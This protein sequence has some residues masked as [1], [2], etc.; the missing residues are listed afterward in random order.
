MTRH[1]GWQKGRADRAA[2]SLSPEREHV[3]ATLAPGLDETEPR[4][5][6]GST[7]S[8]RPFRGGASISP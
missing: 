7:R 8:S 6:A 2:L 4:G 3:R 5:G 1:G